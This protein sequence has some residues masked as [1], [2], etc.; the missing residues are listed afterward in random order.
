MKEAFERCG[1]ININ[2]HINIKQHEAGGRLQCR[3]NIDDEEGASPP[4]V[5][6][7]VWVKHQ[8]PRAIFE[9]GG[10]GRI[11]TDFGKQRLVCFHVVQHRDWHLE[12]CVYIMMGKRN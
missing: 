12:M 3:V 5:F 9:V 2:A 11:F 10:V 7:F 4:P 1:V 6:V 8:C